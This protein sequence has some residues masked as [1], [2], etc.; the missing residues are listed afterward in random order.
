M[1]VVVFI[2]TGKRRIESNQSK[3]IIR[4]L[5][6]QQRKMDAL[7]ETLSANQAQNMDLTIQ[8]NP[9]IVLPSLPMA[10]VEE[11]DD[12]DNQ[13]NTNAEFLDQMVV[14]FYCLS[15]LCLKCLS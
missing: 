13:L 14:T 8:F 1:N 3:S 12:V 9:D 10:T 6:K 7:L 5:D 11:V 15:K 2:Q 4:R